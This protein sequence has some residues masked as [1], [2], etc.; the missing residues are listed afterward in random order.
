MG[1]TLIGADGDAIIGWG[2]PSSGS[3]VFSEV[4]A[5]NQDVLDVGEPRQVHAAHERG[6]QYGG[7]PAEVGSCVRGTH[8]GRP[9]IVPPEA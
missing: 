2:L 7:R 6:G 5:A 8:K 1:S 4:N 3:L 9:P